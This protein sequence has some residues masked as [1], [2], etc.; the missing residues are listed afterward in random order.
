MS[1]L[2]P[3]RASERARRQN[4]GAFTNAH[5]DAFLPRPQAEEIR[6]ATV[7]RIRALRTSTGLTEITLRAS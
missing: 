3:I 5:L 1:A 6:R 2:D 7:V 4:N